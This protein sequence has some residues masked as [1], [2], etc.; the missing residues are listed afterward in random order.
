MRFD[1]EFQGVSHI[2]SQLMEEITINIVIADKSYKLTVAKADEG[3][4][5]KAASLINDRIKSYSSH[6]AFKDM[7]DLLAMTALQFATSTVKYESELSY[8]DQN[9]GQQLQDLDALL[10]EQL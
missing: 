8:R 7:Q 6:Y 3:K 10:S 1:F 9:L 2:K 4:V 5:R